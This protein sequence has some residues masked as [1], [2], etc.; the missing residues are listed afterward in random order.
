MTTERA[1]RRTIDERFLGLEGSDDP[2]RFAFV[3]APHLSRF[4]RRLYG[5]TAIAVSLA[6]IE[7]ATGRDAR[8]ATTQFVSTAPLGARVDVDADVLAAGRHTSQVRVTATSDGELVFA[9]L[10]AA[11]ESKPEGMTGTPERMPSVSPPEESRLAFGAAG[12]SAKVGWLAVVDSRIPDVLAHPDEADGRLCLWVRLIDGE[13][14]T[15]ARLA[16]IADLVPL[17]VA[18]GCGAIGVGTSLDNTLRIGRVVDTSWILV[19]LRPHV[20]D[21]GFG[22]GTV[23]VWAQDGALLATGSQTAS[24]HLLEHDP[25]ETTPLG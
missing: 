3:V 7:R 23:H 21:G 24:M 17:S 4:D 22:H 15:A 10:G 25:L 13:P 18:R 12:G 5:G 20:A 9:A 6:A 1:Q 16:F 8:W 14:V 11:G 19:D 2:G